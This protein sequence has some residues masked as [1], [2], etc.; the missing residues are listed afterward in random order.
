MTTQTAPTPHP[1]LLDR[2]LPHPDAGGRHAITIH[3]P[4][5]LVLEAART[6]DIESV[7]LV[8]TLFRLRARLLGAHDDTPR[9]RK[10]LVA[11]MTDLG[12]AAWP[13]IPPASTSAAPRASPGCPTS[14]SRP[15]RPTSS[16]ASANPAR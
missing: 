12:W 14:S 8:R 13:A 5:P 11:Q 15:S 7:W 1:A 9:E 4:A 10:G 6:F 16:P 2:F 3:A